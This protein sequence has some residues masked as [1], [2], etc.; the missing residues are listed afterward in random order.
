MSNLSVSEIKFSHL[1]EGAFFQFI[2]DLIGESILCSLIKPLIIG[3]VGFRL[4]YF[5]FSPFVIIN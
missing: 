2:T 5:H 1:Y 3:G 4:M